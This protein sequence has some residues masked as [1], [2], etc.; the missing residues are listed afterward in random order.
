MRYSPPAVATTATLTRNSRRGIHNSQLLSMKFLATTVPSSN[1]RHGRWKL[2]H[3]RIR[4]CPQGDPNDASGPIQG[5]GTRSINTQTS[6]IRY[7]ATS[8]HTSN[9]GS[10]RMLARRN[11]HCSRCA[12][13]V[14]NVPRVGANTFHPI[15]PRLQR[16]RNY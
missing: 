12:G 9:G 15:R 4:L 6:T 7:S 1:C 3:T 2:C 5:K 13:P 10:F 8:S 14:S 16:Y 11:V